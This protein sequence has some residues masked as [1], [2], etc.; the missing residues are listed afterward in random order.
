MDEASVKA[1]YG[2]IL[3]FGALNTL[4]DGVDGRRGAVLEKMLEKVKELGDKE[5]DSAID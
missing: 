1:W 3:C 2:N 5:T 4:G